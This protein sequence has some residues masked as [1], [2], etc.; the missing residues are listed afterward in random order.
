MAERISQPIVPES[1]ASLIDDRVRECAATMANVTAD[2]MTELVDVSTKR[3]FAGSST[4]TY[5]ELGARHADPEATALVIGLPHQQILKPAMLLRAEVTRRIIAPNSRAIILPNNGLHQESYT[6]R[7][8]EVEQTRSNRLRPLHERHVRLLE[9]IGVRKAALTGYS[10]G[11][12][13]V[14]GIADVE[15]PDIEIVGLNMDEMPSKP[16][17]TPKQLTKDFMKSGGY[18]DQLAAIGDSDIDVLSRD[19]YSRVRL[20]IDYARFGLAAQNATNKAIAIGMAGSHMDTLQEVLARGQFDA[21]LGRVDGSLLFHDTPP[22]SAWLRDVTYSGSG[23]RLHPTGDNPFA[24]A[25]MARDGLG[26]I[27]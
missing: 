8:E 3:T 17:R 10:L 20:A 27:S 26:D 4:M 18:G 7:P 1:L 14:L 9:A 13:S 11:A 19:I 23:T 5:G 22:E 16:G 24:H 25:L 21:K 15:S 2:M 6:L 12:L